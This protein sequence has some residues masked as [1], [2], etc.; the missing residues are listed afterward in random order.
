MG[1][2][3]WQYSSDDGQT[4]NPNEFLH[5]PE[6]LRR[7]IEAHLTPDTSFVAP[8]ADV[9]LFDGALSSPFVGLKHAWDI[10]AAALGTAV[11]E[12]DLFENFGDGGIE[13]YIDRSAEDARQIMRK[14]RA[15]PTT[16]GMVAQGIHGFVSIIP[17]AIVGGITAGPAG[18]AAMV[19]AST[20]FDKYDELRGQGVDHD[21]ALQ[22]AAI[23]GTVMGVGTALAPYYG[24]KL[25]TQLATGL[26]LNV[27][28][29]VAERAG[30][31]EVL[32]TAGYD[33]IAQQYE[34]WDK[35][36]V[37]VDAIIAAGLVFGGR[38]MRGRVPQQATDDAMAGRKGLAERTGG[39]ELGT[40]S[41]AIDANLARA[42]LADEQ[43]LNGTLPRDM[44]LPPEHPSNVVNPKIADDVV[45]AAKGT[46]AI[47]ADA[48]R[49][50]DDVTAS[51]RIADELIAGETAAVKA[52]DEIPL[53]KEEGAAG[54]EDI[55]KQQ[56]EAQQTAAKMTPEEYA[57]L[58]AKA[59]VERNPDMVVTDDNGNVM[60]AKDV[61]AKAD[62]EFRNGEMDASLHNVAVNCLL[63][64]GGA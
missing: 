44:V 45:A 2:C 20:G 47:A 32:E 24:S 54:P 39:A 59:M 16:M 48:G 63:S 3:P 18:A 28:A 14:T 11:S 46:E 17:A 8:K 57:H 10:G 29:G 33:K 9:G 31:K 49:T 27:G 64:H 26:G 50:V 15:D 40:T 23:T 56:A 43:F 1:R 13:A 53:V 55:A 38:Y 62:E 60:R 7:S 34:A 41:Q 37:G 35:T 36:A 4:M 42:E 30:T 58:E 19:S 25:V 22:G 61:L 6:T 52:A 12:A 51:H 5:T 21:T